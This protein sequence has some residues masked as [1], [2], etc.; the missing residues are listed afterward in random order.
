MFHLAQAGEAS[1]PPCYRYSK[2]V[3][4]DLILP[5]LTQVPPSICTSA[6]CTVCTCMRYARSRSPSVSLRHS[7]IGLAATQ[8][9]FATWSGVQSIFKGGENSRTSKGPSCF[10]TCSMGRVI[11]YLLNGEGYLVL[12]K[13]KSIY[14]YIF[15]TRL[16]STD[17]R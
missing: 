8:H 4:R 3:A 17:L 10:F 5:Y 12:A 14:V 1:Q 15:L 11:F 6:V 2:V 9:G 13:G 7:H 16:Y